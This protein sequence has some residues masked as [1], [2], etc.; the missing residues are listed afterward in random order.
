[1]QHA[2]DVPGARAAGCRSRAGGRTRPAPDHGRDTRHQGIVDLL[3]A[4][5]MN[6]TIDPAGGN[7][8]AFTGDDF[9]RSAD[10]DGDVGL[11]VRIARFADAADPAILD[12]DVRLDDTEVIDNQRVGD[13]GIRNFVRP[14]LALAHAVADDFAAAELHFLTVDGMVLLHLDPEIG[15]RKTHAVARGRAE[16]LG[17]SLSSDRARHQSFPMTFA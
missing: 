11:D 4:N 13:H 17:I 7:D 5:E 8:R 12:T 6:M 16:H 14:A 1:M 10:D 9:R 15:I 3:R 2:S